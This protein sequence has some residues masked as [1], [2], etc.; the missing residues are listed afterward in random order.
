MVFCFPPE[1]LESSPLVRFFLPE[2]PEGVRKAAD[3]DEF[4]AEKEAVA[5]TELRS[6]VSLLLAK[7]EFRVVEKEMRLCSS[8]R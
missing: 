1:S 7:S 5:P 2:E 3:P 6:C 8:S 4:G